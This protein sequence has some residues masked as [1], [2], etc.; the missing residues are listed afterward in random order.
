MILNR[1]A[2]QRKI[3]NLQIFAQ[4]VKKDYE[5]DGRMRILNM[6]VLLDKYREAVA[7][8]ASRATGGDVTDVH[9][10]GAP[11]VVPHKTA[12]K[13]HHHIRS[14]SDSKAKLS[15]HFEHVGG[16]DYRPATATAHAVLSSLS[17]SSPSR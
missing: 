3:D 1:W 6:R 15:D 7:A 16:G 4:V 13:A 9:G 8:S 2:K 12:V 17:T 10:D 11:Q 5:K 14:H